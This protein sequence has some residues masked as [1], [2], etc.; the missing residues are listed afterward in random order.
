MDETQHSM[1]GWRLT[2]GKYDE[3]LN[4]LKNRCKNN[5]FIIFVMLTDLQN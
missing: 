4:V 3:A 2:N 1:S 5:Q